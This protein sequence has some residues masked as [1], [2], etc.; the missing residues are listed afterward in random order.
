MKII[1][2]NTIEK[3]GW[4]P[5]AWQDEPDKV[6]WPDESTGMP[7]L[8]VRNHI[9]GHW[10]GYVGVDVN[11]PWYGKDFDRCSGLRT[12]LLHP[13][14]FCDVCSDGD[15]AESICHI[16]GEGEPDQVWWFGF[17][18]GHLYDYSPG[19]VAGLSNRYRGPAFDPGHYRTL[20]F[21][22]D[23]CAKLAGKLTAVLKSSSS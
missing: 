3:A 8:A 5:G 18:C 12:L 23:E 10:C 15:Q 14:D 7:C 19:F 2:Y 4:G 20:D 16:P 9:L 1:E 13:V 6:Q 21:V 17:A 11:H 22:K